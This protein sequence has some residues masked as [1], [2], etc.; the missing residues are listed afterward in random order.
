MRGAP[1]PGVGG[2]RRRALRYFSATAGEEEHEAATA[3]LVRARKVALDWDRTL[4][5]LRMSSKATAENDGAAE[6]QEANAG[7]AAE[8]KANRALR[9]R[10]AGLEGAMATAQAQANLARAE[11]DALRSAAEQVVECDQEA[12][13][14]ER[15]APPGPPAWD[16]RGSAELLHLGFAAHTALPSLVAAW[17]GQ[18]VAS[19]AVLVGASAWNGVL[20]GCGAALV[21][22]DLDFELAPGAEAEAV[23]GSLELAVRQAS[24]EPRVAAALA[25]WEG[26][27][28]A[29]RCGGGVE[30]VRAAEATASIPRHAGLRVVPNDRGWRVKLSH[31]TLLDV[32]TVGSDA[33]YAGLLGGGT[34]TLSAVAP[35]RR[36]WGP[37]RGCDPELRLACT[38]ALAA[39]LGASLGSGCGW[40]APKDAARLRTLALEAWFAADRG[41][42]GALAAADGCFDTMLAEHDP[43]CLRML[44]AARARAAGARAIREAAEGLSS[45]WV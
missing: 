43:G 2:G 20:G 1:G 39:Q 14:P 31:R 34:V 40:R 4:G 3:N 8:R 19:T 23:R 41:E 33:E 16:G 24:A 22:D 18:P 26:V 13:P 28:N 44:A 12:L 38:A 5:R 17:L 35:Y 45:G 15:G 36:Q 25:V 9:E 7:L 37:P 29:V 6:L 30:A 10:I 27:L 32:A 42:T 21:T 11:R